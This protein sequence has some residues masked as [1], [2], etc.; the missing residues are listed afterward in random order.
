LNRRE[1][2][3]AAALSS[4]I[5]LPGIKGW[6][7]SQGTPETAGNTKKLIVILLRGGI[8]G[9]NVVVPYGDPNYYALRPTIA[10]SQPGTVNGVADLNGYFGL[11]PA[12]SALLPY[13]QDKSLA[14]VHASGS[15]NPTRSH[16]D[17]QDYMETGLLNGNY[18]KYSSTGWLNRLI[19]S[20]PNQHSPV[21]ALSVG[22]VLPRIFS[23]PAAVATV[24]NAKGPTALFIDRPQIAK[25][26]QAM[27]NGTDD[28]SMAFAE[29]M[30]AHKTINTALSAPQQ[31][32][33]IMANRGAPLPTASFGKQLSN[34]FAKD[35]TVQVAFIDFGGWDTHIGEGNGK[36]QLA[37]RLTPLASGLADLVEGLGPL[38]ADTSIVVMSEFGRTAKENGNGGTDH[39]HGNV[40]WLLGG[41]INGGQV[42]GRWSGL[43]NNE[44]HEGR[45]LP[46][47]TDFRS[48]LGFILNEQMK[49]SRKSLDDVF[50]EFSDYGNPFVT[51]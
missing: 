20:I 31:E 45:D 14:F 32:E 33:Q 2:L 42:Y 44:L 6:A 26:F 46:T 5:F 15:P 50:P 37:N 16:F 24:E 12:M 23:G 17:A 49:I 1:F 47:N 25:A 27:Y 21:Q 3:K 19:S 18:G 39:G 36:G 34:L 10:V 48:V 13:W 8:D 43:A 38:Y 28:I 35:S 41:G 4:M 9:L 7:F 22:P 29:G 30:A 51:A 40:M 11:H